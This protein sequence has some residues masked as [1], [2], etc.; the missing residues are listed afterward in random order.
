MNVGKCLALISSS[1]FHLCSSLLFSHCILP[2]NGKLGEEAAQISEISSDK[3]WNNNNVDDAI[4]WLLA[5][6]TPLQ[7]IPRRKQKEYLFRML[8]YLGRWSENHSFKKQNRNVFLINKYLE[9]SCMEWLLFMSMIHG[10]GKWCWS[11]TLSISLSLLPWKQNF[12]IG[13]SPILAQHLTITP[14]WLLD[15]LYG[16]WAI[17]WCFLKVIIHGSV[18]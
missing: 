16:W 5:T 1:T 3:L 11:P 2:I 14:W 10:Q 7:H 15:I 13:A 18:R 8:I 9:M 6:M 17:P 4:Y 12:R